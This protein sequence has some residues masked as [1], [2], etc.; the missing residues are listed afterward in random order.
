MARV[1]AVERL[2]RASK[3]SDG[4]PGLSPFTKLAKVQEQNAKTVTNLLILLSVL[5]GTFY[6]C[7]GSKLSSYFVV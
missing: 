1:F 5:S 7:S 6:F 2:P 4:G 3:A